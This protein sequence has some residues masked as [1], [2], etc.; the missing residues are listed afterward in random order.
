MVE[1]V[2]VSLPALVIAISVI[3]LIIL[4][5]L[6]S[7][8]AIRIASVLDTKQSLEQHV[9]SLSTIV[10]NVLA[11]CPVPDTTKGGVVTPDTCPQLF[12]LLDALE[13]T[14]LVDNERAY[15]FILDAK[16]NM[17]VNGGAPEI[18]KQKGY[19]R[20][21]TNVYEYSDSDGNR[22]VQALLAKAASGG[23][24]VEYKW[25][26]PKTKQMT[27]KISYVKNVPNSPWVLGAGLYI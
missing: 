5:W 18:A 17:V 25:P 3:V 10:A 15:V 7:R 24:Y 20:P 21:G 19:A 6:F 11:T 27:K 16:G 1:N 23:G 22:A 13:S 26:C 9:K 8:N 14:T 12:S 4:F 2:T